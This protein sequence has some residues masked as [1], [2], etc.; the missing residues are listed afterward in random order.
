M[1]PSGTIAGVAKS[2]RTKPSIALP[3]LL[4]SGSLRATGSVALPLS[5]AANDEH[6]HKSLKSSSLVPGDPSMKSLVFSGLALL[7]GVQAVLG[8]SFESFMFLLCQLLIL[9]VVWFVSSQHH[10]HYG[11][12]LAGDGDNSLAGCVFLLDS[13]IECSHLGVV[14]SGELSALG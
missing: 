3:T 8:Y 10:V 5:L 7:R 14:L 12:H 2:E 13:R 6:W 11:Q 9:S 1:T 4:L